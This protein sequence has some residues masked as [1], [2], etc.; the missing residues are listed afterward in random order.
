MRCS[1][2]RQHSKPTD[3][4]LVQ[5]CGAR[6]QAADCRSLDKLSSAEWWHQLLSTMEAP[7][8]ARRERCAL[9]FYSGIGGAEHEL[10]QY[11]PYSMQVFV[12]HLTKSMQRVP[13]VS[14]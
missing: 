8:H 1:T 2:R 7:V 10:I 13:L 4:Q 6:Q 11:Q 12:Q 9:E 3:V 5:S 14:I